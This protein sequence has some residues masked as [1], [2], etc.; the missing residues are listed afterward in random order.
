MR[1]ESLFQS[2]I[3][4]GKPGSGRLFDEELTAHAGPVTC[5]GMSFTNDGERR[6]WFI[7]RLREKLK[8]PEFRKIEGFPV[9]SDE[10][11]LALSDPP[12]YT[13]CPNPWVAD[14]VKEWEAKKLSKPDGW[15]YHREPFAADV[16]EGKNDPIYNAHSYHTKVPHK[17]IMRY[18]L[19]YTEPG[20]IV[21]D[22]FCGTGMVGVA[23]ELSGDAEAVMSLGYQVKPGGTV[24]HEE[25]GADEKKVWTP[26]SKIGVRRSILNDL[27]T[28]ATF[29]SYNYNVPADA[30]TLD[31]DAK[32]LLSAVQAECEW[33]YDTRHSDGRK[34]RINYTVWSDVFVCPECTHEVIFWDAAVDQ[35]AG[36]I[37][38]EFQCTNCGA[39]L[40]KRNAE[41]AWFSTYESVLGSTQ[42]HTK[43]VP[44]LINYS[45]DGKRAEKTPDKNDMDLIAEIEKGDIPY[46]FPTNR[47]MEGR[48]TRRNDAIGLT[49][50]HHFFTKRSLWVLSAFF[51]RIKDPGLLAILLDGF[52]VATIMSRFRV[53]A[54]VDKSTGPMKGWTSGTMYVPS[55]QGEQSWLNIFNEKRSM[56]VRA[57][58]RL[59]RESRLSSIIATSSFSATLLPNNS[60]DY[61]FI[62]PPFGANLNYSELNHLCELWLKVQTNYETEAIE[63]SAHGKNLSDYRKLM[64]ACFKEAYRLLKPGRWMTIEFSNTKASVWNNIQ[65]SLIEA[66]FIVANVSALDKKQGSFKAVT[67]PTAV[68][69]DLVISAYKPNGGFEERFLKEAQTEEGVW[70]FIRTHLGYLPRIKMRGTELQFIPERDPRILF[71]QVIAY[72][73]RQDCPVPISSQEF[74]AGLAQR[75][76]ERDGMYFLPEQAAEYDR[77]KMQYGVPGEHLNTTVVDDE[78]SAIVWLRARLKKAPQVY[79]D[80]QPAFM[81]MLSHLKPN[82]RELLSL[83][84]LLSQNFLCYDG[85]GPVPEQIHAYLSSNWKELRNLSK[86]DPGLRAKACDRWYVPD[87]NKAGDLE[88]LRDKALLKEFEAYKGE[89]KKLKV[90]RLEAVRAGFRK[91]WADRDYATIVAVADKI[92]SS[93]LEE[94]PKLLMWYDQATTRIGGDS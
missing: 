68:K 47:L 86:D 41:R 5:L 55:L 53:P 72:Y 51:S 54:W 21:F 19:H 18:I 71:D 60:V 84:L 20:D 26:F 35:S 65:T 39:I 1:R 62:D 13:A 43:R 15:H 44:V 8:D 58:A 33:M 77:A 45:I 27:S 28:A 91:A 92:P 36:E 73:V 89:K 66:G 24:S 48:E 46:W 11:I 25:I 42:R 85:A 57:L 82:E 75:F 16:S 90:F 3:V 74:Q 83:E 81:P 9:G 93:V 87:P 22:G 59:P 7:E 40:T 37:A 64:L 79:S 70:D 49:H 30:D 67:T 23:A 4:P 10:D 38:E 34:G 88:K 2:K 76:V 94:D 50:A 32:L 69:Q 56:V 31:R 6:A 17:A 52:P 61:I 12:Y 80:I 14:F 63:N 78:Q 29:I